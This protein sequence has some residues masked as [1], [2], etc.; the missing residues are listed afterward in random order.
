M[1][2]ASRRSTTASRVRAGGAA[3]GFRSARLPAEVA[4]GAVA[5]GAR[6]AALF[7]RPGR[8]GRHAA[9][10]AVLADADEGVLRLL[11]MPRSAERLSRAHARLPAGALVRTRN[12]RAVGRAARRAIRG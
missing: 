8:D 3:R 6:L 1:P 9:L 5:A 12:R 11:A 4:D 7:G 10:L 2:D